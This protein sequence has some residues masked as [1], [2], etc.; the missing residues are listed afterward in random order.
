M[1]YVAEE[2]RWTIRMAALSS[3]YTLAKRGS[4][5]WSEDAV[6]D[7]I[8]VASSTDFEKLSEYIFD[9]LIILTKS[10][11]VCQIYFRLGTYI[12]IAR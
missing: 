7:L 9:I 11:A 4:H 5:Y 12:T 3:L 10:P 2:P 6:S 1:T 8:S